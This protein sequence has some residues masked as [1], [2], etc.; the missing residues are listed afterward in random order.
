MIFQLPSANEVAEGNVFTSVCQEFCPQWGGVHPHGQT[1]PKA[2]NPQA[3][4]PWFLKCLESVSVSISVSSFQWLQK[5]SIT[6]HRII[7]KFQ[8]L[9]KTFHNHLKV[10]ISGSQWLQKVFCNY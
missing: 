5:V 8:W 3:D 4:S 2:D 1:P 10:L 9:W 7:F 6:I